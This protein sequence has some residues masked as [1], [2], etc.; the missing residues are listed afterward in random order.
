M[1]KS[2]RNLKMNDEVYA[3]RRKVVDLI[4]EAKKMVPLPRIEIKVT[5]DDPKI[6]GQAVLSSNKIW[7]SQKVVKNYD[8][9]SIVW[10]E[11]VHAVLGVGHDEKC[12]LMAST[13]KG[14]MEPK[15][16]DRLLKSYF[17]AYGVTDADDDELRFESE[18]SRD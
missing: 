10:H 2:L 5:E 16:A 12:P 14:K 13:Y 6:L 17:R 11:L 15:D 4:Y 1:S 7:I 3:L 18:N 8:L 9:R